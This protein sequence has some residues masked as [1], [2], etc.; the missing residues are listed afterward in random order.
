MWQA[1]DDFNE[2]IFWIES[3]RPA[4]SQECVDQSVVCPRFEAAE[5]HPIL[6]T[7]LGRTDHV[8]DQ[9]GIDFETPLTEAVE[10]FVPLVK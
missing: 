8:L 3:L 2:A 1:L 6:H 4:V 5:E 9:V 10:D 7:E